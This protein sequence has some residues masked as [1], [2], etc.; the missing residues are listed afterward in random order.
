MPT[1]A[2]ALR[3]GTLNAIH[4]LRWVRHATVAVCVWLWSSLLYLAKHKGSELKLIQKDVQRLEKLPLHLALVVNERQVSYSDLAKIVNW[5]FCVGIHYVTLYDPR[6]ELHA[7]SVHSPSQLISTCANNS[8][9][10]ENT[11]SLGWTLTHRAGR[12]LFP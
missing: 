5:C 11:S 2:E 8:R 7:A 6:G 10:Q 9:S 3:L 4:A 1:V 12:A